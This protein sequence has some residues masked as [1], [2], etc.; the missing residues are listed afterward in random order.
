MEGVDGLEGQALTQHS[1]INIAMECCVEGE[2]AMITGLSL[3]VSTRASADVV[4]IRSWMD[5]AP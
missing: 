2:E 4:L 5:D 3:P 1:A